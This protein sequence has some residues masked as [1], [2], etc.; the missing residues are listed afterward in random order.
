MRIFIRFLILF[1]L[2]AGLA[3][4]GRFNPGNVVFFYPPNRFDISLNLFLFAFLVLFFVLYF[5]LRTLTIALDMPQKVAA[6]RQ[7]KRER[8]SN[9]A[10]REGLKALFEGRFGHAEKSALKAQD[11]NENKGLATLIGARAAHHMSQ[12]ERRDAWL[13]KIED[14]AGFKTARLVTMTELFV[15]EHKAERALEAVAELNARGKRHIQVLR[16]ALKAN[17]Q[18]KNWNEVLKL[19][20]TLEKNH[21]I[22]PALAGRLREMAYEAL[23]R[24]NEHDPESL[25]Y[26]WNEVPSNERKNRYIAFTAATAFTECQLFDEARFIVENALSDEWDIRLV[27]IYREAAGSEGS[28]ALRMQIERCESWMQTHV[29]EPELELCLGVLCFKQKLWGKAQVHMENTLAYCKEA[30]TEREANLYLAQLHEAI[31]QASEAAKYYRQCAMVGQRSIF[32]SSP[33]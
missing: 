3:V 7:S 4:G 23:L 31:G 21:A 11:L 27:R 32:L 26:V 20:R 12:F 28:A 19:V 13:S 25:R 10:L 1:A 8:D 9:K 15:D 33:S 30:R 29:R 6:Y 14:D 16:W 17:Q 2:A 22:H 5:L 24:E 18:A